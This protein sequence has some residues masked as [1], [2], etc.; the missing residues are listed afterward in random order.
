MGSGV[1]FCAVGDWPVVNETVGE[2]TFFYDSP[3]ETNVGI[4][5]K[6]EAECGCERE[7]QAWHVGVFEAA[8]F[9]AFPTPHNYE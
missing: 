1:L 7:R 2:K 4:L 3:F 5:R 9:L 6:G 8:P